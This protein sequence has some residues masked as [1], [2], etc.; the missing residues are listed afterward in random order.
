MII[1]GRTRVDDLIIILGLTAA[2]GRASSNR[3][4]K[5]YFSSKSS[6]P[7]FFLSFYYPIAVRTIVVNPS[8][9][10]TSG[11][12]GLLDSLVPRWITFHPTTTSQACNVGKGR[13]TPTPS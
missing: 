9:N 10:L 1:D 11:I 7:V 5:P 13:W 12:R 6:S 2:A 8:E 4:I 3:A